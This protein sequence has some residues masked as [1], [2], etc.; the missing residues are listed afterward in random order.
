M[1]LGVGVDV[2]VADRVGCGVGEDVDV[3]DDLA[4]LDLRP[5]DDRVG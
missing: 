5:G 4:G 3:G 2:G 1:G